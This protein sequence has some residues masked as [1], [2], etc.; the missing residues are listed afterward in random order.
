MDNGIKDGYFTDAKVPAGIRRLI[1]LLPT[2]GTLS[3]SSSPTAPGTIGKWAKDNSVKIA[4][5]M[6]GFATAMELA[7]VHKL[8]G[9]ATPPTEFGHDGF[10]PE[11]GWEHLAG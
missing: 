4:Q 10:L 9:W 7:R 5:S 1:P 2:R 6:K 3:S 11:F 8:M